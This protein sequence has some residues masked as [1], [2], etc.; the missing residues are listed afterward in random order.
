L[1]FPVQMAI[2][3]RKWNT[4]IQQQSHFKI[5]FEYYRLFFIILLSCGLAIM[6]FGPRNEISTSFH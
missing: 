6:I 5:I 4:L 3:R 2:F 1:N